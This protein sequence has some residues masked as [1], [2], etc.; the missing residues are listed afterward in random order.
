MYLILNSSYP[1]VTGGCYSW[2]KAAKREADNSPP[3]IAEVKDGG[4]IPSLPL[5]SYVLIA[6]YL[7]KHRDIYIVFFLPLQFYLHIYVDSSYSLILQSRSNEKRHFL[8]WIGGQYS[9]RNVSNIRQTPRLYAT[10]VTSVYGYRNV[11]SNFDRTKQSNWY[12]K[13]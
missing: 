13:Q 6:C 2:G 3:Y 8:P 10:K 7:I 12:C 4:A 5:I 9:L 1:A 11:A